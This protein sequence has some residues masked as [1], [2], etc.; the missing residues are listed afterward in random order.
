MFK[1]VMFAHTKLTRF[2]NNCTE[3]CTNVQ[4]C[5]IFAQ[6]QGRMCKWSLDLFLQ[7]RIGKTGVINHL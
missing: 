1:N 5:A 2:N 6:K 7:L 3:I 4:F